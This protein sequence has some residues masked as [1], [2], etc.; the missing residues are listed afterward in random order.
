MS[1]RADVS[2]EKRLDGSFYIGDVDVWATD[3]DDGADEAD[4]DAAR[5][6]LIG[7]INKGGGDGRA[8]DRII[9]VSE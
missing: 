3:G 2:I 5:D 1:L 6:Y 4:F 8:T 7:V 9:E